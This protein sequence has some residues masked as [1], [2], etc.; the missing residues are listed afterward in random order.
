M[1]RLVIITGLSGSGK[2]T[3]IK[4]LE[5]QGFYCVDNLPVTLLPKFVDLCEESGEVMRV[6]VVIDVR[7]GE[8]LRP[9]PYVLKELRRSGH[10]IEVVYLEASDDVIVRRFSETRRLHPLAPSGRV[11]E[12]IEREREILGPIRMDAGKVVDTSDYNVHQLKR[13]ISDFVRDVAFSKKMTFNLV[14]F[15][16]KYG[17]LYEADIIMDVRFLP[18]P[19]FVDDLKHLTGEDAR[20]ADYV[21]RNDMGGE[22]MQRFS[23]LLGYLIPHYIREGKSYLTISVGCTGGRHRSVAIVQALAERLSG[24]DFDLRIFHRDRDRI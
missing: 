11:L 2:S 23:D 4:V 19:N 24:D 22:F 5:D 21:L 18:N 16:F 10:D 1:I 14:S 3:A 20:V 9:F 15:G 6:G 13:I 12:G 7:G 8:F 17:I